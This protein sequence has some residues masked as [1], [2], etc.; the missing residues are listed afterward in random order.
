M[1]KA[2]WRN[3]LYILDHKINVLV[4]CWKEG[5]YIQGIIHDWSK[6]SPKEFF[7]YAKKFFYTGEKSAEDE[8]KWKHA[9]LHHQHKNKHH[10]EYWVVDPNNKQA[11]PMPRKYMIEMV[12]DWRSFSRKWGRKVKDSTLDLTDK[13]L[14]HPDTK[15]ELEIIMRNKR[16]DDTKVI[17]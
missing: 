1:L 9:W 7:P 14:L 17:S 2:C 11:L 5:L 15:K 3:F 16:G 8:L 6:F 12:C 10:W 13:I 4:E